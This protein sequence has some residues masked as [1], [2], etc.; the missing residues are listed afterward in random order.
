MKF[1]GGYNLFLTGSPSG[2]IKDLPESE[3]LYLPLFSPRFAFSEIA[4]EDG[5][6]VSAGQILAKDPG[7]H[8]VPLL[9][10]RT[11]TVK[12]VDEERGLITLEKMLATAYDTITV[13]EDIPEPA[14][15]LGDDGRKRYALVRLGAWQF[16]SDAF[17][18]K[19]PDPYGAPQAVIVATTRLE[20]FITSAEGLLT[21]RLNNFEKGLEH[22]RSMIGGKPLYL[23]MPQNSSVAS[24]I[25][26]IA[27][28]DNGVTLITVPDKYPCDNIKLCAQLLGLERNPR[29]GPVWAFSV[30]GVLA[31]DRALTESKVFTERIISVAG[32]GTKK[33]EHIRV[34]PGYPVQVIRDTYQNCDPVRL[35]SGGALTG[36]AIEENQPGLDVECIALT[37][38]P[39]H[40]TRELLAF[41]NPGLARH[42]FTRTFLGVLR[43]KFFERYT[44]GLR[45]ERRPCVTC[46]SC[47]TVCP[48]GIMPHQ[49]YK[50]VNKN[51]LED[52]ERIGLNLCVQC[53]LCS[54]VCPSK[55]E[56]K[57]KLLEAQE[58]LL[59]ERQSEEE[60][61]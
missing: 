46:C 29:K 8:G 19:L 43:P 30:E 44:T 39:E 25:R 4:V 17:T 5:D 40:N 45:G 48:A 59:Q 56:V 50:Y 53:G 13:E 9:A 20:P 15:T 11:G 6:E 51:R 12:T 1:R 18:G 7:N 23:L 24:R 57:Q 21:D 14:K 52:A 37:L 61:S 58:T 47:E 55:I 31:V 36:T 3:T 60:H 34:T 10:P 38:I 27:S 42:S 22:I 28:K 35:V 41:A 33:A 54:H 2:E 32:P 16:V 49:V 26:G